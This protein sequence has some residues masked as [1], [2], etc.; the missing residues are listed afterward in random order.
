MAKN[1]S[2]EL[3]DLKERV[4]DLER[5]IDLLR[6]RSDRAEKLFEKLGELVK[7]DLELATRQDKP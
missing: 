1:E 4:G 2:E 3:F 5:Q 7:L 6:Q